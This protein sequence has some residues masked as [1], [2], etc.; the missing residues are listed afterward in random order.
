MTSVYSW[1]IVEAL[2]RLRLFYK[3][4]PYSKDSIMSLEAKATIL[5][6]ARFKLQVELEK[7]Q[8][9][10]EEFVRKK[11]RRVKVFFPLVKSS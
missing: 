9:E 2:K 6:E 11:N 8:K 1:D 10:I 7:A 3:V 5:Y 4:E